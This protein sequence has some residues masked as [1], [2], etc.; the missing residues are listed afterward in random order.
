MMTIFLS[1]TPTFEFPVHRSTGLFSSLVAFSFSASQFF[2][3]S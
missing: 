3:L 1:L 2:S